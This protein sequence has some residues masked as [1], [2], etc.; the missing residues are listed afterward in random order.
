MESQ[1]R[2]AEPGLIP[3]LLREAH[4]FSFFQAVQLL[5]RLNPEAPA[6]GREG[7]ATQ[8]T[9]RFRP[10]LS[11]AFQNA[12]VNGIKVVSDQEG[13]E[14]YVME[15]TFLGL[16]GTSSPLPNYYSEDLLQETD[17]DSLTRGVLDL[18]HHRLISLFYRCW[19]KYRY[20]VQFRRLATDE[21]SRRML[22]LIGLGVARPPE[23]AAV[24]PVRLLRYAGLLTQK[25]TSAAS[26]E[27]AASDY[28]SGLPARITPNVRRWVTIAED[29]RSRLGQANTVLG[30][31]LHAGERAQD[32]SGKFRLSLGPM[33]LEAFVAFL[34]GERDFRAVD[35]IVRL[36]VT[37]R[38]R[39]EIE[40][41]LRKDEIPEFRLGEDFIGARLG[42]TS[43]LGRP[44]QD[45]RIV[46]QEPTR[47]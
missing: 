27:C 44:A 16:Y 20:Y 46:F 23:G 34:P 26:L 11:M 7:P 33:G 5:E 4:H 32:R 37:D 8:E 12:D 22:C 29:R 42:H 17:E 36:F 9:L 10:A 39:F 1:T 35:E 21:F 13:R 14:R 38:L 41:I 45:A 19:E 28:F 43:W 3:K 18:F 6:I 40:V 2:A 31:D 30:V 15:T 47:H 25:P 24:P